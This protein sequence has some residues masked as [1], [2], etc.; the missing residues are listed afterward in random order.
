MPNAEQYDLRSPQSPRLAGRA[1]RLSVRLLEAGV[2]RG[3]LIRRLLREVG[4][5][6]EERLEI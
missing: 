5:L 3:V 1:L 2:T 6:I 4:F